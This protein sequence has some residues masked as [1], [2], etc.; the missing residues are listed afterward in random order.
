MNYYRFLAV[1]GILLVVAVAGIVLAAPSLT[2]DIDTT[3]STCTAVNLNQYTDKMDVYVR[4]DNFPDGYYYIQVTDPSGAHILGTSLLATCTT[5]IHSTGGTFDQCYWLWAIVNKSSDPTQEGYDD[6]TNPSGV[7]KVWVSPDSG[8]DAQKTDNF[9]VLASSGI[10]ATLNVLKFYDANANG[11][12]DDGQYLTGWEVNISDGLVPFDRFT[13]VN[14]T[15]NP[16]TYTVYEYDPLAPSWHNTTP[17]TVEITLDS[18]DNITVEFGNLCLGAGGGRTLGFWSNKNGQALINSTDLSFLSGLN[19]RNGDGTNFDPGTYAAFRTWIL[20]AK[21]TNM[22]Y[23]LSAQLAAM[24]LNVY[25]GIVD[26]NALIYAPGT[27]SANVLGYATVNAV[28][29]EANTELG[30]HPVT[31]AGSLYRAYQED[32][33]DALDHANNNYTFVQPFPC[34]YTFA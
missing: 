20:G 1:V 16:G 26:G 11:I 19:L 9:K 17:K 23:M 2:G 28:M 32:L 15:M 24:E 25:N 7:Y 13:P 12:D 4:G 27:S 14:E 31:T 3:N 22:A 18:G 33:K 5:P 6:T 8:F 10:T 21:A 29:A 34:V 30:L